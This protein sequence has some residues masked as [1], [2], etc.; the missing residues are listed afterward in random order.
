[1]EPPTPLRAPGMTRDKSTGDKGTIGM[2]NGDPRTSDFPPQ[3]G[4]RPTSNFRARLNQAARTNDSWLVIGLDPMI[5]LL[6]RSLSR[7]PAGVLEFNRRLIAATG[8]VVAGY[9][10]NFAFYEALGAA[11]WALLGETRELIPANLVAIA[12]A[13]RGDVRHSAEMY[14]RSILDQLGFDAVTV[15]P[16]VGFE[17]L[18]PFL[19][20]RS[21][22]VFVV[23][24]TS[25]RDGFVQD[26]A[27]TAGPVHEQVAKTA[28]TWGNNAG[29]VAGATDTAALLRI[30]SLAPG[31]P[32]LVPGVG[33]QGGNVEHAAHAALDYSGGNALISC[34]RSIIYSSPH[35][36]FDQ[37]AR[38]QA[39]AMALR[40]RE[41]SEQKRA[42][43]ATSSRP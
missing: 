13:K 35:S 12:D 42:L 9:K 11:G 8:D 16:Y 41:V 19:S 3:S 33:V 27:T 7:D 38:I 20:R 31:V 30:R 40:I 10:L 34:S 2:S 6:P 39:Q 43:L 36:D 15:S 5:E 18:E 14:A 22:G 37:A 25:N 23:C 4:T 24:R 26:M 28:A 21:K 1:M 17:G 29:L 32:F